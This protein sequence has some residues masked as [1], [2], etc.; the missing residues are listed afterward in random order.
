MPPGLRAF[1]DDF[2]FRIL[3]EFMNGGWGRMPADVIYRRAR[4]DIDALSGFLGSKPFF[5][6]DQPRWVDAPVLSILRHID[7][8]AVQLRH[9][10][11][12]RVEE[13]PGGLH[14]PHEGSLRHL[15]ARIDAAHG[16]DTR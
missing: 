13:E 3:N 6:G 1:A 4:A 2:R 7:R 5:M 15:S 10:G 9:Q 16:T 11:L 14:G 12:R 8:H